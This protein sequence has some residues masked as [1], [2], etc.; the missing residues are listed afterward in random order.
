M[1]AM[2]RCTKCGVD[3]P[4]DTIHFYRQASRPCGLRPSCK[5]CEARSTSKGVR[6]WW[7]QRAEAMLYMRQRGKSWGQIAQRFR[8]DKSNARASVLRVMGS[9]H[10]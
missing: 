5:E 7:Q 1:T 8:I 9:G 10:G 6:Q 4:A 2:K 3:K